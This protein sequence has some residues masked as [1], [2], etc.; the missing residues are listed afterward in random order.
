MKLVLQKQIENVLVDGYLDS[1]EAWFTRTQIGELLEYKNPQ[2]SVLLIHNKHKERLDKHSRWYQFDTPSG[3]QEGYVY[4][5]RGVF[6]ICRWSKQPKADA[7][8][9]RLY[10][11]AEEVA[12]KG[13]YTAIPETQ[14]AEALI[15]NMNDADKLKHVVIP[16]MRDADVEQ[17]ELVA[18]YMGLDPKDI[19]SKLFRSSD[20]NRRAKRTI[21]DWHKYGRGDYTASDL[22]EPYNTHP[23]GAYAIDTVRHRKG[24]Y[25]HFA[26]YCGTL[27]FDRDGY[28]M[29][30][31][32]MRKRNYITPEQADSWSMDVMGIRQDVR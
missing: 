30:I 4:N 13:Y 20:V 16:A 8:M 32:W 3:R 23:L 26:E 14:L 2:K 31:D 27:H 12:R 29:M 18:A 7:V 19:S 11:M 17:I 9:D 24:A 15:A 10:D 28:I 6:E 1:S 22:P 21:S 25:G 5:I